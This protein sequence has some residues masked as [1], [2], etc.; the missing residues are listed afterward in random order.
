MQEETRNSSTKGSW[1]E[2]GQD[3]ADG[4]EKSAEGNAMAKKQNIERKVDNMTTICLLT[5]PSPKPAA[6]GPHFTLIQEGKVL[7]P[8]SRGDTK[9]YF[10]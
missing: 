4:G 5:K 10:H 7:F 2:G 3:D 6:E 9:I 1:N 8:W